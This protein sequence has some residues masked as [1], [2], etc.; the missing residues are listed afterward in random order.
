MMVSDPAPRFPKARLARLVMFALVVPAAALPARADIPPNE[1]DPMVR[2]AYVI[3]SNRSPQPNGVSQIQE[4]ILMVHEWYGEQ[5]ARWGHGYKTFRYETE[6]DGVT[7]KVHVIQT[8]MSDD[9][10]RY[11]LWDRAKQAAYAAGATSIYNDT[12]MWVFFPETH[13]MQS[14]STIIGGACWGGGAALNEAGAPGIG[15]GWAMV[16]TDALP[17]LGLAMCQDDR[18]YDGH[19]IPE[20]G[21]YPL[22]QDVTWAWFLGTTFSSVCSSYTGGLAHEMGHGF[23]LAHDWRYDGNAQGN[24][25][26]NGLRG[27]RGWRFPEEYPDE[28]VRLAY[29]SALFLSVNPYFT[30]FR[31]R[32][33]DPHESEDT[34]LPTLQSLTPGVVTPVNGN[35]EIEFQASDD[36]GLAA[37]RL[38]MP[39]DT[40]AEA[41]LEGTFVSMTLSTPYYGTPWFEEGEQNRYLLTVYDT[42]GNT[43]T[44][45]IRFTLGATDNRAPQPHVRTMPRSEAAICEPLTL[46]ASGI[47]EPEGGPQRDRVEWDL[48]GDGVYDTEPTT[49]KILVTSYDTQGMAFIRLRVTDPAGASSESYPVAIR[50]VD[51]CN[52]SGVADYRDVLDRTSADANGNLLPDECDLFGDITGDRQVGMDDV[53]AFLAEMTGPC[54]EAVCD[55]PAYVGPGCALADFESDGDLDLIDLAELQLVFGN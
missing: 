12:E 25:M 52:S 38:R 43:M 53:E 2:I 9:Y 17:I 35:V 33:S 36:V 51:D 49:N 20:I 7:P 47:V 42:S 37:V 54:P 39:W 27:Y 23:G 22:I 10:M 45:E 13:L 11:G 15:N 1:G 30:V 24:L 26:F 14:D 55:P 41:P 18:P 46:D 4:A 50:I 21:P 3:P 29:P 48:D 19:I 32:Q 31:N 8:T 16:G 28:F 5:L 34:T 6:A 44:E 40:V